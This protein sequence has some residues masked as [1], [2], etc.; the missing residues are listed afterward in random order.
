MDSALLRQH[1]ELEERHWWFV[2]RRRVLL[3]VL[4]QTLRENEKPGDLDILEVGC[5]GGATMERLGRHGRVRGLEISE[6]AVE[7]NRERGRDVIQGF[8]EELP[9]AGEAFD[10]T[11]ALDVI[12]HLPDDRPALKEMLRVLRPAGT[13]LVTVPALQ[14]LWG[15][16]DEV[17][18]HQRRYTTDELRGRVQGAG[19]EVLKCTYF[20]T[21]LFPAVFAF[22]KF[23]RSKEAASDVFEVPPALNSLLAGIFSQESRL[24]KRG[25]LPVGVSALCLARKPGV[26]EG[27]DGRTE[28]GS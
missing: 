6:E 24:L 8:A 4:E 13:L 5:G 10:I 26:P 27:P 1:L 18:G 11:L 14:S 12:E 20:N 22:R 16:H 7:F 17:N 2:A 9:F 28:D 19:F 15:P 3:S 23:R 25:T 21:L